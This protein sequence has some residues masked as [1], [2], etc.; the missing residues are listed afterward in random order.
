MNLK[1]FAYFLFTW[2]VSVVVITYGYNTFVAQVFDVVEL[3][4]L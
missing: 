2:I 4:Y 1:V 3:D